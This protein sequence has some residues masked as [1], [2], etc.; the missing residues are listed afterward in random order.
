MLDMDRKIGPWRLRVWGLVLNFV[1]NVIALFGIVR[2]VQGGSAFL[3][4]I[5][6]SLT[7]VCSL[8][9]AIPPNRQN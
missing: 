2:L 8:T 4:I 3:L 9:L 7:L 6:A 1:G 5:G